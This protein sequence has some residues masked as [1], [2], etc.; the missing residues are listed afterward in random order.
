ME[1]DIIVT[2][3]Q[4]TA[5]HVIMETDTILSLQW[6]TANHVKMERISLKPSNEALQ[7]M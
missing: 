6:H 7:T 5:N 3:Q 4:Y 2:L 1:T